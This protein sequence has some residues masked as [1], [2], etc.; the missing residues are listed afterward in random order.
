MPPSLSRRERGCTCSRETASAARPRASA[1][2]AAGPGRGDRCTCATSPTSTRS[3]S[4]AA[5]FAGRGRRAR[6][7][8]PQRR[9]PDRRA[10]AKRPGTSSSPSPPPSRGPFLMTR[11]LRGRSP[12][13]ERVHGSS[14]SARAGC[15]PPARAA[16]TSSSTTA[17]STA[18]ASTPMPSGPRWS[19][20]EL[21]AER[22]GASGVGFHLDAPR[23]GR[24]A[25]ASPPRSRGFHKV[26][27]PILRDAGAGRRHRGLADGGPRGRART[28]GALWHDRRLRS[29]TAC[30][31]RAS[32]RARPRAPLGR[33]RAA[34]DS[35]A[36]GALMP[37][38]VDTVKSP[39]PREGLRLPGR[40]LV[41]RRVGPHGDR[42]RRA[43]TPRRGA[44]SAL[45]SRREDARARDAHTST[46][47]SSSSGRT[48]SS[49]RRDLVGDLPR[50]DHLRR[51]RDRD[52][53]DLRR[54][55]RP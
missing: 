42:G 38:F 3:A 36:D 30:P 31:A 15:S 22:E 2:G 49:A 13:A 55:A 34:R 21:F 17:S 25:R 19:C 5:D 32:P 4:F 20:A 26:M 28:P 48:A 1:S 14:G 29:P 54:R 27:G 51:G 35:R 41:G 40:L 53:G 33:A 24:H 12:R 47:R 7:P 9:R 46:R 50:H 10:R 6:R 45:S 52:G 23:L 37:R 16:T 44:G 43:S 11:L 18:R 8:D 39:A